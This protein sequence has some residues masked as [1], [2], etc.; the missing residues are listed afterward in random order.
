MGGCFTLLGFALKSGLK[1][2]AR[3][4]LEYLAQWGISSLAPRRLPQCLSLCSCGH[5]S[6]SW[7][8]T[9]SG[10]DAASALPPERGL[11]VGRPGSPPCGFPREP[12]ARRGAATPTNPPSTRPLRLLAAM[13]LRGR[14]PRTPRL[15]CTWLSGNLRNEI[16]SGFCVWGWGGWGWGGASCDILKPPNGWIYSINRARVRG[17]IRERECAGGPSCPRELLWRS[18]VTIKNRLAGT[19][20]PSME[21]LSGFTACAGGHPAPCGLNEHTLYVRLAP[22]CTLCAPGRPS[23]GPPPGLRPQGTLCPS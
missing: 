4:L 22:R 3:T 13:F 5:R 16:F 12:P 9:F 20:G 17:L 1:P 23:G 7:I 10:W 18:L 11:A 2:S 19:L 15:L 8:R 6:A 14:A 21:N